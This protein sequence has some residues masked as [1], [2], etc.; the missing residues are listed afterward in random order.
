[1]ETQ[2]GDTKILKMIFKRFLVII[3]FVA[4]SFFT[5]YRSKKTNIITR[6]S[7]LNE[8]KLTQKF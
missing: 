7:Q 5:S 3:K 4:S 1:M 6:T 2:Q 8:I